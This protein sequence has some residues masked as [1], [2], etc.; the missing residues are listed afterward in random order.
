MRILGI[1]GTNGSGKDLVG[2]ILAE[3]HDYLFVSVSD[4]LR[5]E[6]R[7]RGLPVERENLRSIS[8]EWRREGGLGVLIDKAVTTYT[9][10]GHPY[11]GLA[12][13]SLRNPGEVDR[14]HELG[15]TVVWVDARQ[16]LRYD[17]IQAASRG[18]G[19]E[20][21]KTF[22]QFQVEELAEMSTTGDSA[23]LD[24]SAV[25]DKADIELLNEGSLKILQ[26]KV[27]ETLL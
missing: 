15:G 11:A 27:R 2:H 19:Q 10:R 24:M 1:A 12:I 16:R 25:R 26:E 8:A 20:D 7:K 18:R 3:R 9:T 6:C 21:D 23:T 5:D 22:E 13:S 14:V 4:L 17:R